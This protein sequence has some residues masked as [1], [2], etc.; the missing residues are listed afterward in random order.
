MK[1]QTLKLSDTLVS[2]ISLCIRD[3]TWINWSC[4]LDKQLKNAVKIVQQE[5]WH[6][7]LMKANCCVAI[8]TKMKKYKE[9]HG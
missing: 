5:K 6:C 1:A 7:H 9:R 3:A 8:S 2:L 4:E